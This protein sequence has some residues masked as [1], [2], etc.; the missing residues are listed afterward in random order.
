MTLPFEYPIRLARVVQ[1]HVRLD[2]IPMSIAFLCGIDATPKRR[3]VNDHKFEGPVSARF[4]S[5]R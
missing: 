1:L 3:H 5:T 2:A 4:L